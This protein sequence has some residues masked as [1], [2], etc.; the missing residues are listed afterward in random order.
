MYKNT[1][2]TFILYLSIHAFRHNFK[3]TPEYIR[4][5]NTLIP[6]YHIDNDHR[7]QV[8]TV[9]KIYKKLII[10]NLKTENL[11]ANQK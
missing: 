5:P 1:Y 4:V 8:Y 2:I 10:L 11:K 7:S 9:E 3:S 6:R